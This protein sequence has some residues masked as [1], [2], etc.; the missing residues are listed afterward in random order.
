MSKFTRRYESRREIA[1]LS[2]G[3]AAATQARLGG[4]ER[5]AHTHGRPPYQRQP[6]P[7]PER[8]PNRLTGIRYVIDGDV[9]I[10]LVPASAGASDGCGCRRCERR[11]A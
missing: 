9:I 10:T 3:S 7:E 11:A 5:G 4:P 1:S 6:E 8:K 2:R